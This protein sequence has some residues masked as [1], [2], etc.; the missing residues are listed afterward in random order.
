MADDELADRVLAF[1]KPKRAKPPAKPRAI[2]G[3]PSV[4]GDAP[5]PKTPDRPSRR[6]VTTVPKSSQGSMVPHC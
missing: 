4:N 2:R 6:R 3:A 1:A 5:T